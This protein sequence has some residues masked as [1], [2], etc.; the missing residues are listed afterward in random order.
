VNLSAAWKRALRDQAARYVLLC[1][2]DPAGRDP[3]DDRHHL[4]LEPGVLRVATDAGAHPDA[5]S[6][7][8]PFWPYLTA[9]P[10]IVERLSL[11]ERRAEIGQV[12]LRIGGDSGVSGVLARFGSGQAGT[13]RL[14]LWTPGLTLA[15]ALPLFGG[16]ITNLTAGVYDD[17]ISI[18]AAGG[19]VANTATLG[20]PIEREDFPDAPLDVIGVAQRQTILGPF[21]ER[22]VAH[23]IDAE[24]RE[25]YLCD[26]PCTST[27]DRVFRGGGDITDLSTTVTDTT[28]TGWQYSKIILSE[29]IEQ[30][31]EGTTQEVAASGGVGVVRNNAIEY[32]LSDVAGVRLTPRARLAVATLARDFPMSVIATSTG[33]ALDIVRQQLI[34]QTRFAFSMRRGMA[35]LI[36]LLRPCSNITASVGSNLLFRVRTDDSVDTIDSVYNDF[37][38]LCGRDVQGSTSN[39]PAFIVAVRLSADTAPA[40][41]VDVL[42]KSEALAGKRAVTVEAY[43]LA[44]AYDDSGNPVDCPAGKTLALTMAELHALPRRTRTY[45]TTWEFGLVTELGD[46][47][48][49]T[50]PTEGLTAAEQTIVGREI[51]STGVRLTMSGVQ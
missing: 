24:G 14:D 5:G 37:V 17:G 44:V 33:S 49:L 16:P 1:T 2:I 39:T 3:A 43:D 4:A 23:Q 9:W 26:P 46:C 20:G 7:Y 48:R 30:R 32:L 47:I 40:D 28:A 13:V 10:P 42:R 41:L 45:A 36:D 8:L 19:D 35:D 38:I 12:Q 31:I 34:P 27:P 51:T 25:F 15:E 11:Q 18:T 29:P 22:V 6:R 50:D 21:P